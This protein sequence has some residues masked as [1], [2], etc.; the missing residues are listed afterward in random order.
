MRTTQRYFKK[1]DV[2]NLNR[3]PSDFRNYPILV[4]LFNYYTGSL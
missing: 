1:L 4:L 3:H 2:G